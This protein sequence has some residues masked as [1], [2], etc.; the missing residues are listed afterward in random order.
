MTNT[1][2]GEDITGMRPSSLLVTHWTEDTLPMA[3]PQG[4]YSLNRNLLLP[5]VSES[6]EDDGDQLSTWFCPVGQ[7]DGGGGGRIYNQNNVCFLAL[8]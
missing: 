8:G 1:W 6:P 3:T 7:G 4:L 5:A 2:V